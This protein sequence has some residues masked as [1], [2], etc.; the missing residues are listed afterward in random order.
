MFLREICNLIILQKRQPSLTK[1]CLIIVICRL[2]FTNTDILS[3]ES[4]RVFVVLKCQHHLI[5][6]YVLLQTRYRNVLFSATLRVLLALICSLLIP[7]IEERMWC[8]ST[9]HM[10][11]IHCSCRVMVVILDHEAISFFVVRWAPRV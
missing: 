4:M 6:P 1:M 9:R 8:L 3:N 11:I 5:V 2:I 7:L 10:N